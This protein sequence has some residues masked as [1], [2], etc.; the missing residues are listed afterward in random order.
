MSELKGELTMLAAS[1]AKGRHLGCLTVISD[2]QKTVSGHKLGRILEQIEE[3]QR[4]DA[5]FLKK[6]IDQLTSLEAINN[7]V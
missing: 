4:L 3:C 6:V 1:L 2:N 5:I 7:N